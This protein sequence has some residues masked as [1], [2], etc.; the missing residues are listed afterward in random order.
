MP[1][2]L[3]IVS[4]EKLLVSQAVDMVVIPASEGDIGVLPEHSP[5]IVLLRGG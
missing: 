3:E 2:S 4:P 1:V 5:M